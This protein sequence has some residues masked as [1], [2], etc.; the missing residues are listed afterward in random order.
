MKI[1][2]LGSNGF[3]GRNVVSHLSKSYTVV[4]VNR[5]TVDLLNPIDVKQFL[6]ENLFDVVVNCAAT[7]TDS[8]SINDARNNLGMFMNFYNNSEL[9]GKFINTGSGAE[10]DRNKDI[11]NVDEDELFLRMPSD[12]YGWGQN[13]K[14]RLCLE[15]DQFY[16]IRIF[17]CF[18]SGELSTRLFPR[19]LNQSTLQ[20]NDRYFDYF[21]IQDLL[22][23]IDNCIET[24]WKFK[25]IN[26]VYT[27]KYTISEV[28][29]KFFNLN[30]MPVKPMN[31][32]FNT[33]NVSNYTG[34]GKRLASMGIKLDGL[35]KG[36]I[37]Y[38]NKD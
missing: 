23:V 20:I 13:I 37:A 32:I 28:V 17:N 2:V 3:I 27:Q 24:E 26:A 38:M 4:P 11:T 8:N 5:T 18:G 36:L 19:C 6:K 35:D 34:S 29:Q 25:D 10:F 21:S 31:I 22:K 30:N 7:M 16:T 9:F 14:S 12:S 33:F 1:A 15:K